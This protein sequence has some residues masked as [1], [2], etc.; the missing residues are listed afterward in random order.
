M[1]IGIFSALDWIYTDTKIKTN[2]I[3]IS[4]AKGSYANAQIIV[5]GCDGKLNIKSNCEDNGICSEWFKLLE[6][7]VNRNS[8]YA[9]KLDDFNR[10]IEVLEKLFTRKAPFKVYEPMKPFEA[11]DLFTSRAA[12]YV[13]FRIPQNVRA[14]EYSIEIEIENNGKISKAYILLKVFGVT[15]PKKK[16]LNFINWVDPIDDIYGFKWGSEECFETLRKI[17]NFG[18]Y[19]GQN[20]IYIPLEL[21]DCIFKDDKCIFDFTQV[22]KYI[23][24]LLEMGYEKIE[25]LHLERVFYRFTKFTRTTNAF[26]QE[27]NFE[28]T[29]E[30]LKQWYA[31]LKENNWVDITVQHIKDEPRDQHVEGYLAYVKLVCKYMPNVPIIEAVLTPKVCEHID[32]PVP[33]TRHYQLHK[34]DYYKACENVKELW[35]YTCCWPVAPYLNRFLDM[36]LLSPRY[37]HWLNFKLGAVGY[38][39][40][41]FCTQPRSNNVY[42]QPSFPDEPENISYIPAGDTNIIYP[43]ENEPIG[44][45][46]LEM[47][48]AGVE[49]YELLKMLQTKDRKKADEISKRVIN[50]DWYSDLDCNEFER[51]YE[52]LLTELSK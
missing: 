4:V 33:I 3:N 40:W 22:K 38:L 12:L 10:P 48:R 18:L 26:F 13:R 41:G 31:F 52:Q 24:M 2:S 51:L 11:D 14:G 49:D 34:S 7:N 8:D 32:I 16:S 36:P 25:G 28:F 47:V 37:I 39:H 35:I 23:E 1:K 46:R 30:F 43:Y 42:E 19:S 27:E 9:D 44:S 20:Y 45:V 29:I 5:D 6:V 17:A 15:I 50:D 21:L